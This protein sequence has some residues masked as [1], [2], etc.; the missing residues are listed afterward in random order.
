MLHSVDR[1]T[2]A[3]QNEGSPIAPGIAA[4]ARFQ[5]ALKEE[6]VMIAYLLILLAVLT[7]VIPH[8]GW[9][10]FTAVTG[11]LLYFGA[12]RPWREMFIPLAAL[13]ATDYY[14]TVFSYHY[15]FHWTG[16]AITWMWYVMAMVLGQILLHAKTNFVRV[17]AG[18]ILGPTSFFVVSNFGV[19]CTFSMYPPTLG[20]LG[21]CYMAA[22]PFYRNDLLATSLVLGA[23]YGLPALLHRMNLVRAQEA[24]AAK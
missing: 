8:A 1:A 9:W 6:V 22:I 16:Y 4:S 7:R 10:N 19:W 15:A 11:G 21:T 3:P 18:A 24:L 5:T 17:A 2:R 12:K 23:A 14:L 20:G 13:M